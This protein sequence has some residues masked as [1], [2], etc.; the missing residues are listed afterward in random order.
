MFIFL[1]QFSRCSLFATFAPYFICHNM[2]LWN[3]WLSACL[4]KQNLTATILLTFSL[5]LPALLILFPYQHKYTRTDKRSCLLNYQ[6]TILWYHFWKN[7]KKKRSR[8][9]F[10]IMRLKIDL[11]I[12]ITG[13]QDYNSIRLD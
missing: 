1:I 13:R 9:S 5:K 12:V 2:C 11:N 3:P 7:E 8:F 4:R 6:L 10:W